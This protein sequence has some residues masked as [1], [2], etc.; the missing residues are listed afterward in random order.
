MTMQ[1]ITGFHKDDEEHWVAELACG[2]F[3][4]VRHEPP[5]TVRDWTTTLEG[6]QSMIGFQLHCKKCVDGEPPDVI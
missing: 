2:H 3:Q 4:H 6:Q 5:W 1:S